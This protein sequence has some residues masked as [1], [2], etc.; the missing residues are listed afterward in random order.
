MTVPTA[1]SIICSLLEG[2]NVEAQIS[3]EWVVDNRDNF[4]VPW[5]VGKI[6]APIGSTQTLEEYYSGTGNDILILRVKPILSLVSISYTNVPTDQFYISPNTIQVIADEAILKAKANFNES[7]Y[8]PIFAKGN[9]NIRIKYQVGYQDLPGPLAYAIKCLCAEQVLGHI[10]NRTGGGNLNIQGWNRTWG[11][12]GKFTE[13]RNDLTR[14]GMAILKPLM[15][16]V[17]ST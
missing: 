5:I 2:Y 15:T 11:N 1:K 3:E 16:G 6:K 17:G 10:A 8:V 12:R 9:R 7:N 14:K 13:E 4:V